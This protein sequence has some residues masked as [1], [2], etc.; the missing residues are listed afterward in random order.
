LVL[1]GASCDPAIFF[2]EKASNVSVDL[3]PSGNVRIRYWEES[4]SAPDGGEV[5]TAVASALFPEAS[6]SPATHRGDVS[7]VEVSGAW[8]SQTDA[9]L[10]IDGQLVYDIVLATTG[11]HEQGI[12]YCVPEGVRVEMVADQQPFDVAEGCGV[13]E[14]ESPEQAPSISLTTRPALL[15]AALTLTLAIVGSVEGAWM[16]SLLLRQRIVR[17]VV[18]IPLAAGPVALLV[19]LALF[20]GNVQAF[21][22]VGLESLYSVAK[23]SLVALMVSVPIGAVFAIRSDILRRRVPHRPDRGQAE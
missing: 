19:V 16:V 22:L 17:K 4:G 14:V 12:G 5:A 11:Q 1:I 20:R 8:K 21:N 15:E 23:V 9:T 2:F 7:M 3:Q 6:T 18:S 13:W 10:M